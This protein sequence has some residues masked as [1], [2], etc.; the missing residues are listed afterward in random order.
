VTDHLRSPERRLVI[1]VCPREAGTVTVAVERGG[2]RR[3]LDARGI[4]RELQG[5]VDRRGLR[6][7]VSVREGCAGGCYVTGPNVSLTLHAV[8]PP[9]RR[10]DNIAIGWHSYVGSLDT[11]DCLAAIVEAHLGPSRG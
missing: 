7:L 3:R 5:L 4:L 2:R 9:G 8:P 10:P 11:L 1:S 6:D